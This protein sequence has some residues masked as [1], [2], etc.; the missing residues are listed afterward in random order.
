M[1]RFYVRTN[2]T[3][4]FTRQIT[5]HQRRERMLHRIQQAERAHLSQ[6][7]DQSPFG[8]SST[9]V[10]VSL[11]PVKAFVPFTQSESLPKTPPE[12][13][14]HVSHSKRTRINLF[15]WLDAHADDDALRVCQSPFF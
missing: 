13:H 6:A 12:V 3:F 11:E 2:K 10:N 15:Q 9:P 7:S 5:K 8:A 4:S 14:S 1:K